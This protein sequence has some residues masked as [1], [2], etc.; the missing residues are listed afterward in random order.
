MLT[1]QCYS[2]FIFRERGRSNLSSVKCGHLTGRSQD[3]RFHL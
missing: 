2:G 3:K 1:V